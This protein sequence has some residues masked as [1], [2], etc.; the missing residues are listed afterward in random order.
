MLFKQK[1]GDSTSDED[2]T[3][4]DAE[5]DSEEDEDDFS[6]QRPSLPTLVDWRD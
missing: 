2:Y 4:A 5:E 1:P 6:G 3:S